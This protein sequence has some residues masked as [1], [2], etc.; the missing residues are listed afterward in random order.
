MQVLLTEIR[1]TEGGSSS[2]GTKSCSVSNILSFHNPG[3]NQWKDLAACCLSK[4]EAW[5]GNQVP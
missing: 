2:A 5:V 3:F 4:P 1:T